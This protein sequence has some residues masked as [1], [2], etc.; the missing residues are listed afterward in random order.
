MALV[1][2]GAWGAQRAAAFHSSHQQ[3]EEEATGP[4]TELLVCEKDR[5][6]IFWFLEVVQIKGYLFVYL[7]FPCIMSQLS[8]NLKNV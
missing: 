7:F 3:N 1:F 2:K 6:S 8:K 4:D 5:Q